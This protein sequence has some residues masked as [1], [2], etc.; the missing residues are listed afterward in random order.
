AA[1][2]GGGDG[3]AD[4]DQERGQGDQADGEQQALREQGH[5]AIASALARASPARPPSQAPHRAPTRPSSTDATNPVIPIVTMRSSVPRSGGRGVPGMQASR[6]QPA[7]ASPVRRAPRRTTSIA[8]ATSTGIS[9]HWNATNAIPGS[10]RRNC[11][12]STWTRRS[13]AGGTNSA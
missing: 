8:T 12:C 9:G 6:Q 4:L 5:Q 13:V 1:V 3:Q 11:W 10:G 2:G 7:S